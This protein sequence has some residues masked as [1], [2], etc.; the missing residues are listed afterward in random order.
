MTGKG[1][2][3]AYPGRDTPDSYNGR[4]VPAECPEGHRAYIPPLS[5]AGHSEGYCS[6]C[7][8]LVEWDRWHNEP[9]Y[10]RVGDE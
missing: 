7:K 5:F 3:P 9:T 4:V 8:S 1:T 6:G 2:L 10:R